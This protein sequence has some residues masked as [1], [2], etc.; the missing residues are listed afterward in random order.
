M[1]TIAQKL[2]Y[3]KVCTNRK[4]DFNKGGLICGLTDQQ[5]AF[6]NECSDFNVDEHRLQEVAA[7]KASYDQV[8]D[9]EGDGDGTQDMIWGAVWCLGGLAAT[10]ADIGY[11]FYGAIIFGGIQFVQGLIKSSS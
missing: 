4:V 9:V 10:A 8:G 7:A 5:A 11:I 1:K 6:E 2:E 3:C